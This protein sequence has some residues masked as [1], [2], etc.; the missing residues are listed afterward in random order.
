MGVE[1][2][3]DLLADEA[4]P[5]PFAIGDSA[6]DDNDDD[7]NDDDDDDDDHEEDSDW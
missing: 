3:A 5:A 6:D 1:G 4:A 7:D 2:V